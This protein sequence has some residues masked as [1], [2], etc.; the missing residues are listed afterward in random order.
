M[1]VK[2]MSKRPCVCNDC[3]SAVEPKEGGVYCVNKDS[4]WYLRST[5]CRCGMREPRGCFEGNSGAEAAKMK[6]ENV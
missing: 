2:I 3:L 5:T 1:I 6:G 4:I